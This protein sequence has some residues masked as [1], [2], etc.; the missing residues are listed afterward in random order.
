MY[1]VKTRADGSVE[2][3]KARLVAQ[4]FTQE[5]SIGYEM[6]FVL[7]ARLTSFKSLIV[8]AAIHNGYYFKWV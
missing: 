3:Y 5:Y 2:R 1:K 4:R 8:V 7:V 6:T